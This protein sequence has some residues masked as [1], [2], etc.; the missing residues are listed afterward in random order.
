MEILV[1]LPLNEEQRALLAAA[2]PGHALRYLEKERLGTEELEKAQI[3]LGNLAQPGQLAFCKNLR[4]IQLNNAG[5]EGYCERLPRGALLTNATGAYGPVMAEYM[6]GAVLSL[7]WHSADYCR[8][9]A[10][11]CWHKL[12]H[13]RVIAGS[14][15]LVVGLGDIGSAFGRRMAALGATVYGVR[16][17][18]G[19]APD[20]L[21]GLVGPE[22][23]DELLPKADVV[24]LCLP[25]NADTRHTLNR[26]RIGLLKQDAVV[27]NVG[28]GSAVDTDALCE[29]LYTGR[30]GGAALDV[31]D[32]EPLPPDH[33]LW[34]APNTCITPHI[35]GGYAQ[36]QTLQRVADLCADN[37]R[38]Y[39]AGQE[40]RSVV[41]LA[42][43]YAR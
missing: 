34:A 21:A 29:A 2:A 4:W 39:L 24:A 26:R 22:G 20:W 12:G 42:T 13:A 6:V 14:T 37:L 41:D 17:R 40:L 18:G 43:G 32:P 16:R 25:G 31:T 33:P 35:A 10:R 7:F 30:L 23:L 28:R 15:V 3:I 27:V 8:Q 36:P 19:R 5:T 1:T 38:R 11:R 9:Q